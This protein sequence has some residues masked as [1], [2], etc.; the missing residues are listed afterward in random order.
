MTD[1]IKRYVN[2]Y[3][4][5]TDHMMFSVLKKRHCVYNQYSQTYPK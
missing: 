2:T 3:I 1:L 4:P 5:R